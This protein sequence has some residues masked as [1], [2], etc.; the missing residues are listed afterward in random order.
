MVEAAEPRTVAVAEARGWRRRE[1][2]GNA[3]ALRKFVQALLCCSAVVVAMILADTRFA[4]WFVV[5]V[6]ICGA[7]IGT[8]AID[9]VRTAAIMDPASLL[10][11]LGIHFFFLAPLLHVW[12]NYWMLYVTPPPDWRPWLGGMALLNAAGLVVYRLTRADARGPAAGVRKL[13]VIDAKRATIVFSALMLVSAV[14]QAWIYIRVGGLSGYIAT[15]MEGEKNYGSTVAGFAGMGL[16]FSISESFPILALFAFVSYLRAKGKKPGWGLL[17]LMLG[18]YL[19]LLML[20]GGL[21]GSRSNTI[22]A[23]FWAA[24][25]IHSCLRKVTRGAVITAGA[26]LLLF[27]Y[28]YGFYKSAGTDAVK[29]IESSRQRQR[30]SES[31]GRTMPAVILGDLGRSDVQAFALYKLLTPPVEYRCAWGRTYLGA[32]A[33]SI[34]RSVWPERPPTKVKETTE[35]ET[36]NGSFD[37]GVWQSSRVYGLAGE[38]MLNFGPMAAPIAFVM[39]GAAVKWAR[40]AL[41]RLDPEDSRWLL[42]PLLLLVCLQVLINDLDIIIFFVVKFGFVPLTAVSLSSRRYEMA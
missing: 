19:V 27:M 35:L 11:G 40:R 21:R 1:P 8:D 41:A 42:A 25:I 17:S 31:T 29:A 33:L 3:T 28:G 10:G 7:L 2:D 38:A 4:H 32:L 23:L 9:F 16:L 14:L 34:P 24:G 30:L 18:A 20:F 12:W 13:W 36:G 15:Y 5:P 26:L 39:L 6:L 37:P 22:W